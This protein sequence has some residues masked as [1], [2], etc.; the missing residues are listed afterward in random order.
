MGLMVCHFI[1]G[2]LMKYIYKMG[3]LSEAET[4]K[5]VR[6]IVSAIDHLHKA[7]IIHRSVSE[8]GLYLGWSNDII[9]CR[10]F[11]LTHALLVQSVGYVYNIIVLK[12]SLIPMEV[13][14]ST[15]FC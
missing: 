15:K 8:G 3:R 11:T 9:E 2:E 12:V 5:Y 7:G 4:R 6:Q 14:R 10:V 13:K 1:G